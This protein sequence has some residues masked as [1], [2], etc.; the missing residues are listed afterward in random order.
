[1][2][3]RLIFRNQFLCKRRKDGVGYAGPIIGFGSKRVGGT[4]G[5]SAVQ[6]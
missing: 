6:H 1:M 5:K 3:I 4:V 2:D